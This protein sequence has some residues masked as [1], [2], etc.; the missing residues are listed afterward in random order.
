MVVEVARVVADLVDER[1]D[2]RD[3]PVALLQVDGQ[4]RTG[5]ARAVAH[6]G[7]GAHVGLGV[8]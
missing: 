5:G 8:E 3:Q 4:V 1:R 6:L 7:K 2:V